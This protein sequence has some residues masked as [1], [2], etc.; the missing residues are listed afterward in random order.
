M[1]KVAL[2]CDSSA[3]IPAQLLEELQIITVPLQLAVGDEGFRDGDVPAAELYR[4]L[5]LS[6]AGATT[7]APAPGAFLEAFRQAASQAKSILCLTL[8]ARYSATFEAAVNAGEMFRA[9]RP[10]V[11]LTVLD[12]GRLAMAY[13]FAVLTAARRAA[14]GAD[15][16]TCAAAAQVVAGRAHLIGLIDDLSYLARSGRVPRAVYWAGSLLQIVPI[17]GVADGEVKAI[18]RVRTRSRALARLL[19][20]TQERSEPGRELRL[21]VLH[22]DALR[23]ARE[24]A[25]RVHEALHPLELLVTEFTPVMGLHSGPGLLG[26]AFYNEPEPPGY[27]GLELA[28]NSET[29]EGTLGPLPAARSVPLLVG[30]SGLP[31]SG[32]SHFARRLLAAA[33]FVHLESDALRRRIFERPAYTQAE[34]LQLFRAVHWVAER[35]LARGVNTIVDATNLRESYRETLANLARRQG[36]ELALVSLTAPEALLRERLQARDT[37]GSEEA[38]LAVYERLLSEVEPPALPHLAVDSSRDIE[39]YVQQVAAGGAR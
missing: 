10:D 9:E 38:G 2:V 1:P 5:R 3:C 35:L 32:K 30:L 26:L 11:P 12:S 25:G 6:P 13:G 20:L 16:A 8:S 29:I 7:A 4:R 33:P 27:E 23:Q 17:L 21:A 19:L 31:G 37:A 22:A 39:P 18:E 24:L 14:S 36:A 15:L 28:A 34:N